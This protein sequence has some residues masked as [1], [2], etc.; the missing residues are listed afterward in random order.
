MPKTTVEISMM[1]TRAKG[2]AGDANA[3]TNANEDEAGA[4]SD[5]LGPSVHLKKIS[6]RDLPI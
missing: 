5:I 2:V 1:T 4:N 3:A 6:T